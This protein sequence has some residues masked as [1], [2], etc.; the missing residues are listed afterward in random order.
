MAIGYDNEAGCCVRNP[1][2]D[3]GHW[4]LDEDG[5][6]YIVPDNGEIE[7]PDSP[8]IDQLNAAYR[9]MNFAEICQETLATE[10]GL[11]VAYPWQHRFD[12]TA[13]YF[14]A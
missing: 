7:G 14:T 12:P 13:G 6:L 10:L 11:T 3:A 2:L 5:A 9:R 1:D 8:M 4:Y